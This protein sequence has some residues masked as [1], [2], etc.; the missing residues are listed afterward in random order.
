MKFQ[1][2]P[3][4]NLIPYAVSNAEGEAVFHTNGAASQSANIR[5]NSNGLNNFKVHVIRLTDFI[6]EV[7]TNQ[8]EIFILKIDIEGLE[9]V[10]IEN[11]INTEVYKHIGYIFAETHEWIFPELQKESKRIQAMILEKQIDNI[12]L[13]WV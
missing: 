7:L 1:N 12:Y 3:E 13:D 9:Y 8:G 4:F 5:N 11:I 6:K 10:V 2:K